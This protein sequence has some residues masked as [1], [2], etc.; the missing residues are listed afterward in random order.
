MYVTTS[1]VLTEPLTLMSIGLGLTAAILIT[2]A[3]LVPPS[4]IKNSKNI[5]GRGLIYYTCALFMWASMADMSIQTAHFGFFMGL[6]SN[7]DY[8]TNG[9]PYLMT[10]IGISTQYWNAI[11]NYVL[12]LFIIYKIDNNQDPRNFVLYWCGSICTSQFVLMSGILTGSYSDQLEY[13]V[14]MNVTFVVFPVWVLWKYL[15]KPRTD[16]PVKIAE[17]HQSGFLDLILSVGLI[18][19]SCLAFV[20][21]LGAMGSKFPVMKYYATHYEPHLLD[22]TDFGKTW[23]LYSAMYGIPFQLA[24]VYGL[25]CPGKEWMLNLSVY[26][27]A[28]MLQGSFVFTSYSWYPSS[29][30]QYRIPDESRSTVLCINIALVFLANL[31]M[32]R[33]LS[34]PGYFAPKPAVQDKKRK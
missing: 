3:V 1:N 21:V 20:R 15:V 31:L 16:L 7:T 19:A 26:Y 25:R 33:C 17:K 23:A 6:E 4:G 28:S 9:E 29:E 10:P 11:V 24:A 5:E 32:F 8:F 22:E 13:A 34:D 18:A 2:I 27:A 12:Y 14:W 30:E